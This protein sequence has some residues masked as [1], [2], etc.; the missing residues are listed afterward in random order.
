ME[1]NFDQPAERREEVR[2]QYPNVYFPRPV[3]EPLWYGRRSDHRVP[4]MKALVDQ[5]NGHVFNVVSDQ[6]KVVHY[7]D[8]VG[9]IGDITSRITN[10]GE[11]QLV[12]STLRSGATF[13]LQLRFPGVQKSIRKLDNIVPK[14]DVLSSIDLSKSLIGRF[15]AFR[16]ICTNGMGVWEMFKKFARKH[17]VSLQLA[18][19]QATIEEGLLGFNDQ[20]LEWKKWSNTI[21]P[22]EFYNDVWQHLPFSAHEKEKIEVLPEVSTKLTLKSAL[23]QKALTVWDLN[24][25]LTQFS[26]HNIR[27]DVRKL[28]IEPE[29]AR[30][31]ESVYK[32]IVM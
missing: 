17:L 19:L 15:G 21:I 30:V 8:L 9:I 22:L 2:A 3:L 7:E 13:K 28:D 6:Y 32:R 5:N 23:E 18:D 20:V 29:I 11:I 26:T 16:L 27:S 24:S 4:T 1:E 12:P 31:V 25:V 14:I 10:Y